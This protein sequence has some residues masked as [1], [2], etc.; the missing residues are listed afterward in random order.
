MNNI[1]SAYNSKHESPKSACALCEGVFAHESW[2]ATRDPGASYAF[3]I[4][5][6]ASKITPWDSLILHSLGV[7][8]AGSIRS[9]LSEP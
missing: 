4:V 6:D 2:C 1:H 8:W 9:L 3:Q 5:V 7:A